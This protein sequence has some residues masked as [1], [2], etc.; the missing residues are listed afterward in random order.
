[1]NVGNCLGDAIGLATEFMNRDQ[2]KET[3][4]KKG[5]NLSFDNFKKV[6]Q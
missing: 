6:N 4:G 2:A 1:M 3:Y 5:E